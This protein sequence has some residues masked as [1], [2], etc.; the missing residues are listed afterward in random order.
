MQH[1]SPRGPKSPLSALRTPLSV[2]RRDY[3]FAGGFLLLC[4]AVVSM[5]LF[6]GF[7][8]GFTVSYGALFLALSAYLKRPGAS[9]GAFGCVCGALSLAMTT[10][11]FLCAN[12][13]LKFF[14]CVSILCLSSVW[15]YSLSGR[16]EEK[17][18]LHSF[19]LAAIEEMRFSWGLFRDRRPEMYGEIVK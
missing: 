14:A 1:N 4:V 15:F 11:F 7:N 5:G 12:F 9:P 13:Q 3:L 16:T 17:V 8:L 2:S 6:G 19:D 10:V 18:I